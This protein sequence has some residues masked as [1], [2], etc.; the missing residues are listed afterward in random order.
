MYREWLF[1]RVATYKRAPCHMVMLV[2][3][4]RPHERLFFI[5]DA[6]IIEEHRYSEMRHSIRP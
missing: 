1:V 6:Y 4:S 3:V 2:F 5:T